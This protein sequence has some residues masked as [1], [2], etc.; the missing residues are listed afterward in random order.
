VA[1]SV[2]FD[3]PLEPLRREWFVRGTAMAT[4]RAG[5]DAAVTPRIRHPAADTVMA[6]DP[7]IPIANQRV[8][9][10]ASPVASGLRW[11]MDDVDLGAGARVLWSPTPG[12]HRLVLTD[13]DGGELSAVE[14]EVRGR[15]AT[16]TIP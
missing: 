11:R 2:A 5:G 12:R 4:V 7:D 15:R 13:A 8:A 3:P 14:F 16:K 10:V 1:Q 6:L 9:L